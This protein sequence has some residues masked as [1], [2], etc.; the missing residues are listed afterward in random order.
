M[1]NGNFGGGDGTVLNP[2]LVEDAHDFASVFSNPNS[3]FKQTRDINLTGIVLSNEGTFSGTYDGDNKTIDGVTSSSV[4]GI[5]SLF[6]SLSG[7]VKNLKIKVNIDKV[8][9][10]YAGGVTKKLDGGTIDNVHVSG[11]IRCT[12]DI[13]GI[14]SYVNSG[15]LRY[16]SFTGSIVATNKSFA[17]SGGL[18]GSTS[19]SSSTIDSCWFDG[20]IRGAT[21]VGGLV[22]L[23]RGIKVFN[24]YTRGTCTAT[25]DR[26]GGIAGECPTLIENCYSAMNIICDSNGGSVGGLVGY[27]DGVRTI[28]NSFYLGDF[29]QRRASSTETTFGDIYGSGNPT[30][31]NCFSLD[32]LEFR[33]G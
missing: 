31:E 19:Q 32:T 3:Y 29:I 15:F 12:L 8:D 28:R 30:V 16:C 27:V 10:G 14:V 4:G 9:S 24:S 23:G 22:G 20:A 13:G 2:Y 17:Y 25:S 5:G 21:F 33:E 1:A 6:D 26:A 11:S 7:V 18:V